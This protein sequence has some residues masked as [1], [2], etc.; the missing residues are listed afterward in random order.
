VIGSPATTPPEVQT[1]H[2][3][4]ILAFNGISPDGCQNDW[5]KGQVKQQLLIS[6]KTLPIKP[7]LIWFA[8]AQY[9]RRIE[10]CQNVIAPF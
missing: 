9:Q 7:S 6:G 2:G 4:E 3:A 5:P 10:T 8:I 1:C